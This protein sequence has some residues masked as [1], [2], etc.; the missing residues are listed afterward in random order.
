MGV[1]CLT[2]LHADWCTH[3]DAS[4]GEF[5]SKHL[6]LFWFS[7]QKFDGKYTNYNILRSLAVVSIYRITR[8][9]YTGVKFV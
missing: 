6:I 5:D 3:K 4:R 2:S 8:D 1:E 7:T 9:C